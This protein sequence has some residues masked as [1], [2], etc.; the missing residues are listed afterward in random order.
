[1]GRKL[2]YRPG[3]FYRVDDRSGFPTRAERTRKE[4]NGFIVDEKL[5]EP[6]QPQDLVRGVPDYQSVPDARPLAPAAFV[7]P[8]YVQTT[9]AVAPGANQIPLQSVGF[10]NVGDSVALMLDTG[11][12]YNTTISAILANAVVQIAGRVPSSAASG[13]E[14]VDYRRV[15]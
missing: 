2:H 8:V 3:S 1:M 9:A 11:V 14:F 12:L 4:W 6:R 13:N 15:L 5:W 7:G 10:M